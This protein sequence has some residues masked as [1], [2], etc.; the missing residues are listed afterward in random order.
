LRSEVAELKAKLPPKPIQPS[1]NCTP[2][3]VFAKPGEYFEKYKGGG[4]KKCFQWPKAPLPNWRVLFF[5][6]I[7]AFIG[8]ALIGVSF[9]NRNTIDMHFYIERLPP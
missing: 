5:S 6:F 2:W 4:S 3:N 8:I 7:A 9:L 1:E